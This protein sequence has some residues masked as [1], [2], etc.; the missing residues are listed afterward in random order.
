[1]KTYIMNGRHVTQITLPR[2]D[3]DDPHPR[4][5]LGGWDGDTI[6]TGYGLLALLPEGW[7]DIRLEC[8]WKIEGPACWYIPGHPGVCPVGLWV[9][10]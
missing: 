9:Q 10:I 2:P 6:P 5:T 8:S 3:D 7:E 4:L 1:M